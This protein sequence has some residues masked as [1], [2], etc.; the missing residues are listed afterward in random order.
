[1][2]LQKIYQYFS[3]C[4]LFILLVACTK[5]IPEPETNS[6]LAPV[7]GLEIRESIPVTTAMAKGPQD[8]FVKHVVEGNDVFIECIVDGITFREG[9]QGVKGK[10]I[11]YVDGEK[12]EEIN[13]AAFKIKGLSQGKHHI[14]LEVVS[15]DPALYFL[16]KEFII[17]VE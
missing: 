14:K 6:I 13:R 3:L 5:D 8:F 9:R 4:I 12:T 7:K 10:F 16:T 2:S 15:S 1:M 17:Q 11:V